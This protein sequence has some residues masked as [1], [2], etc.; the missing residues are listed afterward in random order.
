[1]C[2]RAH[3]HVPEAALQRMMRVNGA[4]AG[5]PEHLVDGLGARPHGLVRGQQDQRPLPEVRLV[6]TAGRG[7]D[8]GDVV[9]QE[10]PCRSQ[11]SSALAS[12]HWASAS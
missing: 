1:M 12:W 9:E 4:G 2:W 6:A 10:G 7:P 5:Q 11:R 8:P 3:P